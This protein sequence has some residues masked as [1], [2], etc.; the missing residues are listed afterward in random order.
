M[1]IDSFGRTIE[2]VRIS[3]TDRCNLRCLYCTIN[4]DTVFLPKEKIMSYEEI[5]KIAEILLKMGL[6]RI[7]I[8]GGE[9]LVRKDLPELVRKL[10]K[11]ENLKD[12]SLTTNGTLLTKKTAK[13]LWTAGL[14]RI[15]VSLASLNPEIYRKITDGG[16]LKEAVKGIDNALEIGFKPVKIN[17]VLLQGINDDEVFDLLDYARLKNI[18]LRFIEEMPFS[19][20]FF[21]G[22]SNDIIFSLLKPYLEVNSIVQDN[23]S[24]GPAV[25]F[26]IKGGEGKIGFISPFSRPFCSSCNRIRLSTDGTILPCIARNEGVNLLSLIRKD[27]S[28]QKIMEKINETVMKKKFM[29]DGFKQ[30]MSMNRLGG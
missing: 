23:K 5:V 29:H 27:V 11:L 14:E 21:K 17:T 3:I 19:E 24:P 7:K 1:L 25:T 16:I 2:T 6:S 26:K 10:S 15:N 20:G 4:Q 13:E 18:N 22:V 12:L 30:P 8:T 9:P 28:E